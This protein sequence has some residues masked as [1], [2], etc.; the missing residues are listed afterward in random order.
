MDNQTKNKL[1]SGTDQSD[2][3]TG[4]AC[5]ETPP[6]IF[7]ALDAEFGHFDV[8]LCADTHRAL[9]PRWFGPGSELATD[10]LT[11]DWGAHGIRGYCNPPYGAFIGKI[12]PRAKRQAE[13]GF[14]SVFL[15]PMR[16]TKAFQAHIMDGAK[17][18]RFCDSRIV[19]FENGAPR[20]NRKAFAEGRLVADSAV[21]DSIVV[22]YDG[23]HA[24]PEVSMWPVPTHVSQ[25]DMQRAVNLLRKS[26]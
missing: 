22:V 21:F 9:Y 26:A 6:A 16:V 11:A 17:E 18:L 2:L 14:Q 12:L 1:T 10:A 5:W 7:A 23:I 25:A 4:N 15:I 8:D 13:H 20:L 19:F 3:T 24:R